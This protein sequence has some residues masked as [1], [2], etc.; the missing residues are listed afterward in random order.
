LRDPR[1]IE[2]IEV[3][4]PQSDDLSQPELAF[5]AI[6]LAGN[7]ELKEVLGRVQK[8]DMAIGRALRDVPMPEGLA[9][10]LLVRL[11]EAHQ[12]EATKAPADIPVRRFRRRSVSVGL[13][14]IA[15]AAAILLAFLPSRRPRVLSLAEIQAKAMARFQA[16]LDQKPVG[17]PLSA[18][19]SLGAFPMSADLV[20][21]VGVRWRD[22]SGLLGGKAVAYDLTLPNGTRATLYVVRLQSELPS[23]P[24]GPP[25]TPTPMTQQRSIAVWKK[26]APKGGLLYV[27]AV[28]GGTS[29]YRSLLRVSRMPVA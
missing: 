11:A 17:H 26:A 18:S 29:S 22:V 4:R 13:V 7:P 6:Q 14:A 16:D 28:D 8:T 27:L 20:A 21:T 5:L 15:A 25:P 1:L 2:A 3:C 10:R 23:L 12:I 24:S 9:D 19:A